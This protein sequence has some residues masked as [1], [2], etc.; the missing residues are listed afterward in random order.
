MLIHIY[1]RHAPAAVFSRSLIASSLIAP[2]S[3][4]VLLLISPDSTNAAHCTTMT[5]LNLESTARRLRLSSIVPLLVVL[6]YAT[7]GGPV[8]AQETADMVC[9]P[10]GGCIQGKVTSKG[11]A[12]WS[13]R[14][15]SDYARC[16]IADLAHNLRNL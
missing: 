14:W 16:N 15:Y 1:S 9:S 6:L 7:V 5:V 12:R 3:P 8:H 11:E 10:Q 4:L 13:V 2:Y